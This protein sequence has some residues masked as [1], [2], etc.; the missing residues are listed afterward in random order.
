M[1]APIRPALPRVAASRGRR[2]T[3]I[4]LWRHVTSQEWDDWRWQVRNAIHSV[5]ELEQVVR[6]TPDEREGIRLTGRDF[7]MAIPP[8]YAALMD[9]SD[10]SCPVRIQAI[11]RTCEADGLGMHD[12]LGED[13]QRVAPGLIHRYPD[14]ALLL[15]TNM[16]QLY[17]RHCTR[18]RLTGERKHALSS[19]EFEQALT[20]LRAHPEVRDVLVSGGDPLTLGDGRLKQY[21]S[22]LRAIPS[23]EILRIG[24]RAPVSLPQRVTPAL[25]KMLR[26]YHPLWINTHFNHPKELT[27]EA[28]RA[29]AMI[30]DAGIPLG[31]QT[32]LLR[33]VNSSPRIMLELV[34]AL[35]RERVRPHY[36]YQCDLEEGLAHFRT[37]IDTAIEIAEALRGWTSSLAVP[38][39]VVDAPGGGGK[40][41]VAPS[42]VLSQGEDRVLLRNF[43]GKIIAYPQPAE[44]DAT[45]AYD[46]KW[47]AQSASFTAPRKQQRL[48]VVG[49]PA[50]KRAGRS[51]P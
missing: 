14:R 17:C 7:A 21:L 13:A 49:S 36:V 48:R 20:Y 4:S 32:V 43:E 35:V 50:N 9:P 2:P 45:C 34:R 29:C 51:V 31:N 18:K 23:I 6:L 24:T 28:R 37:S 3:N 12:S 22:E 19:A 26:Q 1:T 33:G 16:C 40:I 41:P 8:Y 30:V 11:P 47:T 15:V 44:R 27:A 46:A 39:V 42:Y 5:D 25:V 10:P 38:T